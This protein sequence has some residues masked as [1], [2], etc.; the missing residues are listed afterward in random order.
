MATL[1]EG[2]VADVKSRVRPMLAMDADGTVVAKGRANAVKG[3]Q[4]APT[5]L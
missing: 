1:T 5:V 4:P 3:R 2:Q